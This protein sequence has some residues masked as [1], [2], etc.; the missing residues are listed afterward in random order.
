MK[1]AIAAEQHLAK[2]GK[3][4]DL[5]PPPASDYSDY[6]QCP[7]CGRRFNQT[8]AQRHIPNCKDMIHN[9][10]GASPVGMNFKK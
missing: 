1:S 7:Y 4:A 2:G 3:A 8:A 10:P 6:T 9:K 5:P